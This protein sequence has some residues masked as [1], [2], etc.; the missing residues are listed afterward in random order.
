MSKW[1]SVGITLRGGVDP[2]LGKSFAWTRKQGRGL[3]KELGKLRLG[4]RL[5]GDV[6]K[7]KGQLQRLT[8][9][10]QRMGTGNEKLN[11]RIAVTHE[12]FLKAERS[13]ARYGIKLDHLTDEQRKYTKAVKSTEKAMAAQDARARRKADRAGMG[14]QVM[15][16]AA[17]GMA[18]AAPIRKAIQ[19][20]SVMSDV[21]KVVQFE[22]PEQFKKMGMDILDLSTRMP[23]AADGI[24]AI[25]AAAGQSN[26]A[27]ED[28]LEF[29][30]SA[31]KMGIAFDLSGDQA[32]EIMAKW[33]TSMGLTQPEVVGLADAVNHL[34]NNMS[35]EAGD[36]AQVVRRMGA[37]A[38]SSGLAAT[39]TAALG[40]SF[41]AAGAGPEVAGTALKNFL[42]ALTRGTAATSAQRSAFAA[43]GFDAVEM[44]ERMQT[45]AKGAIADVLQAIQDMDAAEQPA[46][47]SQLF[48]EESKAA[49]MPLIGN[50]QNLSSAFQLVGDK[51]KYAGSMQAEYN[52]KKGTTENQ[53]QLAANGLAKT[54]IVVG[55]QF[56]PVLSEV[57]G[58]LTQGIH[59][60]GEFAQAHPELIRVVGL[61][62][63][64]LLGL[65]VATIGA[66]FAFGGVLDSVHAARKGFGLFR[67]G[68]GLVGKAFPAVMAALRGLSMAMLTNPIG[69]AITGIALA[70]GLIIANWDKV[71]GFFLKIWEPIK[72]VWDVFWGV[73]KK[74]FEWT[75]LGMI[76]KNWG[77]ITK[78]FT[79]IWEPVKPIWDRF[80]S[81]V[82]AALKLVATPFKGVGKVIG[83]AANL[84][85]FGGEDKATPGAA[86]ATPP[87]SS[88]AGQVNRAASQAVASGPTASPT[89]GGQGGGVTVNVHQNINM[90]GA[91]DEAGTRAMFGRAAED[92]KAAVKQAVE[93]IMR[94][95]RR[96]SYG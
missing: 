95:D 85:G 86:T 53:L 60:V 56:L 3:S 66:K 17:V 50:V 9:A 38:K 77:P 44:A 4:K 15:G 39:E 30:E 2:S 52:E 88:P 25:V 43:L 13:A 59:V 94:D 42:G 7:Y 65:K 36:L 14:G 69:L 61:A 87:P 22:T 80:I 26:I 41:L 68:I 74:I 90:G 34:S 92:F 8:A 6:A 24:A 47:I 78:F 64:G 91:A 58:V 48:G 67:S 51:A 1:H 83:W 49:I 27:R 57:V 5:A 11:K 89:T 84:L 33:R 21:K 79:K 10:Q 31:T 55:E 54:S 72:P 29:A 40:A 45:D 76:M 16:V 82:K 19:F 18:F 23:M 96:L 20:E 75:P 71:K 62:G 35:A 73:A 93:E 32:G 37:V 70:A 46:I 63:A 12:R 28:L 81:W